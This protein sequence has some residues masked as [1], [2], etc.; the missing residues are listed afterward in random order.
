MCWEVRQE[1]LT[2]PKHS[3]EPLIFS[4]LSNLVESELASLRVLITL[5]YHKYKQIIDPYRA[6]ATSVSNILCFIIH[7]K[8]CEILVMSFVVK[9]WPMNFT[10]ANIV[11]IRLKAIRF[12]Q[13]V[14]YDLMIIINE[15]MWHDQV[16]Y[17]K[18]PY[19]QVDCICKLMS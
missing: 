11:F 7:T 9:L 16:R 17:N 14:R 2:L 4:K 1:V 10:L 18:V 5:Y 15:L 8:I 6:E 19:N 3:L 12:I 13:V